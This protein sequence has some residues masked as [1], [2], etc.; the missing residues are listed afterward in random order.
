MRLRERRQRITTGLVRFAPMGGR[1]AYR[2]AYT[3][4]SG[5]R[6]TYSV[7]FGII[8]HDKETAR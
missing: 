3:R 6:R 1:S 5:G 2:A 7:P 8:W 4:H